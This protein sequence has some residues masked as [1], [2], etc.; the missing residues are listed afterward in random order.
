M[1]RTRT[2]AVALAVALVFGGCGGGDDSSRFRKDYNAA[3]GRLAAV[4]SQIAQ[5]TA[6]AAPQSNARIAREFRRIA[7]TTEQTRARLAK[8]E[9]PKDAKEEYDKLL[10]SLE[11]GVGDLKAV[12]AAARHDDPRA[13]RRAVRSLGRS[14]E[15]ITAAEDALRKAVDG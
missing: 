11:D 2:A 4:N 13:A 8:L 3:V 14:G 6:G 1:S 12:A 10:S 7:R 9:P 15:E 5:A